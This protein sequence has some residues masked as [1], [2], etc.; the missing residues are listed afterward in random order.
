VNIADDKIVCATSKLKI[1]ASPTRTAIYELA[2]QGVLQ[3]VRARQGLTGG[4]RR[5]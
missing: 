2:A 5:M 3:V 1:S 4:R